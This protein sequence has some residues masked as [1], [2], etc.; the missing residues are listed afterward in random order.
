[1]SPPNGRGRAARQ[2]PATIT[3]NDQ[4]PPGGQDVDLSV[5]DGADAGTRPRCG[6]VGIYCES[7]GWLARELR[8]RATACC[9]SYWADDEVAS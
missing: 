2:G 5:G 8:S 3:H 1:M 7:L 9:R 4:P 6:V